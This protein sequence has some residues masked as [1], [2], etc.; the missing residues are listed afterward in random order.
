M[1]ELSESAVEQ[2]VVDKG[3]TAFRIT[4]E[5]I[6]SLIASHQYHVFP[7]TT[8]TVC[9]LTLTNGFTVIGESACI[10]A[11]N[12]DKSLGER[13]AYS[14]AREK[15]W[16]LEGYAMSRELSESAYCEGIIPTENQ[17]QP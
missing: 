12:F 8:C 16:M 17:T 4:P 6:D 5:H 14:N 3:L 15:L 7:G 11:S 9:C 10:S 1:P 13:I 2:E